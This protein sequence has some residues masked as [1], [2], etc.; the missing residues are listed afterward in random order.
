MKHKLG[1]LKSG[2]KNVMSQS[3]ASLSASQS[4][5]WMDGWMDGWW[6]AWCVMG[7]RGREDGWRKGSK[8]V[9]ASLTSE[10]TWLKSV[11]VG[12]AAHMLH[13]RVRDC[14]VF[15]GL[16]ISLVFYVINVQNA[17]SVQTDKRSNKT[18]K[19]LD[20]TSGYGQYY[21]YII[22]DRT[23]TVRAGTWTMKHLLLPASESSLQEIISN[24]W[25]HFQYIQRDLALSTCLIAFPLLQEK[26]VE[27][28]SSDF[29]FGYYSRLKGNRSN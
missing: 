27:T 23:T 14:F 6:S 17:W 1:R 21:L 15:V 11:C 4:N 7:G 24:E 16:C 29:W 13:A 2:E 18:N 22:I 12:L 3:A 26:A 5:G 25:W 19:N 28:Q 8:D 9:R 20:N 10:I